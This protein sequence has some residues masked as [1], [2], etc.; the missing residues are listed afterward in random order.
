MELLALFFV[1]MLFAIHS[2]KAEEKKESDDKITDDE[3]E[4]VS[5]KVRKKKDK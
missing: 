4:L 1:V 2:P 3:Y 5:V